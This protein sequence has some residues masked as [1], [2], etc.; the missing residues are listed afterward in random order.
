MSCLRFSYILDEDRHCTPCLFS[1]LCLLH[2]CV[3]LNS[4]FRNEDRDQYAVKTYIV[5]RD[6]R[7][8][9]DRYLAREN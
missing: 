8:N 5:I 3:Y 9:Q 1:S 7:Q 6:L 4:C 2:H